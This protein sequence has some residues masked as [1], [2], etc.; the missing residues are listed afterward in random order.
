MKVQN[1]KEIW[2]RRCGMEKEPTDLDSLIKLDGFDTGAGCVATEDWRIYAGFIA[3]RIGIKND[4]TVYEVGCGAGAF[5]YALS[6][7]H[8]LSVS[9]L[10]YSPALINVAIQAIPSGEFKVAEANGIDI[11]TPYDYVIANSVFQYFKFDYAAE[12]LDRM[13]RKAKVAVAILDV[14]DLK[15]KKESE[16]MRRETLTQ[17][18][19]AE[20]Y[21]GL[22]HTY[23]ERDWFRYQA[24]ARGLSCEIFDGCIPNYIQNKYR[25]GVLLRFS[26]E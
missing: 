18:N 21:A 15:T 16:A 9:G 12:V 7:R 24:E 1:W 2:C 3:D 14:P 6:E 8:S 22:E 19:Y 5:L 11:E 17:T 10:D 26:N 23:F 20:K 13:T 25:F 4:K